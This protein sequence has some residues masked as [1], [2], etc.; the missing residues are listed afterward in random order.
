MLDG[1][2]TEAGE[3]LDQLKKHKFYGRPIDEV[4]LIEE[5]GDLLWYIACLAHILGVPLHRVAEINID[6]LAFRYP[7]KFSEYLANNRELE[8]ERAVLEQVNTSC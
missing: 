3:A 1:L 2:C 7:E 4:N 6:K 5:A 8:G